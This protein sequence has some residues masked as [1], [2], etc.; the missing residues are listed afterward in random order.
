M[1]PPAWGWPLPRSEC[2]SGSSCTTWGTAPAWCS[3]PRSPNTGV[4]GPTTRGVSRCPACSGPSCGPGRCACGAATSPATRSPSRP[5][6]CSPGCSSTRRI[7]STARCC[8]SVPTPSSASGHCAPCGSVRSASTPGS[9]GRATLARLVYL[10]TPATAVPAL[11]ALVGAGHEIALVVSQPDR[12]RGLGPQLRPSPVKPAPLE[13]GLPV[14]ARVDD[15]LAVEAELGVVVAF[16]RLIKPHVLAHLEMVNL[17]F[18]LLPRWRGAAPVER[19]ILA[20]DPE[21]GVCLMALEEGLD[22]GDVFE[23]RR[24]AIGPDEAAEELR[25]RLAEA[26]TELLVHALERGRESLPT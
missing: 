3:T 8:W 6:S 13:H 15:L 23:C 10:G 22:T 26:G 2:R 21:T 19:A 16:G 1:R 14:T 24:L 5:T 4:S 25:R 7:I 12:R 17:H 11:R 18:S 9:T 20:G